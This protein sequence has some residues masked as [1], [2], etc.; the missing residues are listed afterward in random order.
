MGLFWQI[1]FENT[2]ILC[3]AKSQIHIHRA[4]R[5]KIKTWEPTH[6]WFSRFQLVVEQVSQKNP[7]QT[8]SAFRYC[9][10]EAESAFGPPRLYQLGKD[11]CLETIRNIAFLMRIND[12]LCSGWLLVKTNSSFHRENAIISH[13]RLLFSWSDV[14]TVLALGFEPWALFWSF[15]SNWTTKTYLFEGIWT[16]IGLERPKILVG[17][18]NARFWKQKNLSRD[19]HVLLSPLHKRSW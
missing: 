1:A 16:E 14:S 13:F 15:S 4:T 2:V 10:R 11:R 12:L 8:V 6:I 9:P 17:S 5:K 18:Q 3:I 7:S 19:Y